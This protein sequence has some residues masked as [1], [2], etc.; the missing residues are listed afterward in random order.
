MWYLNLAIHIAINIYTYKS[1]DVWYDLIYTSALCR[2]FL[3]PVAH[4]IEPKA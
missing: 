4:E 3:L 1:I 2:P